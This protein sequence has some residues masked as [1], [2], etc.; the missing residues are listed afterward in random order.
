MGVV[1]VQRD[2][3]LIFESGYGYAN[4]ASRVPLGPDT[5]FPIASLSKQFTA[6]A[7]L[8]LQEH[9]KLKTSDSIRLYYPNAPTQW[10]K[11]MLRN[12][13]TQTSGIPDFDFARISRDSPHRPEEL[14]KEAVSKPLKFDPG[15][16]NEYTN[17]NYILLGKVVERAS[18]QSFCHFMRDHIFR[19]LQ[20]H[21]TG[22]NWKTH[23]ANTAHGYR[24][25]AQGPVEYEDKDL[26]SLAGAGSLY[27]SARDMIR[28]TEALQD[29]TFLSKASLAEMTTP[30]LDG[31]AYGL[32]VDGEGAEL[33]ISHDGTVEGF[34]S[35][36][37]YIPATRTTVVVLS[38]LNAE[39]NLSSPGTAALDTEV[40][41]LAID[42]NAVLPSAGA[43]AKVPEDTLHRYAGRYRSNDALHPVNIT[44]TFRDNRLFI[45]NDT[46]DAAPLFAES[47]TRFY[48]KNQETE[49][50]FD[51]HVAGRFYF[52]NYA[53]IGGAEFD[54]I[55][56]TGSGDLPPK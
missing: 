28:W 13:L 38:N 27:S 14:L 7:I 2:H 50:I 56:E 23:L 24:P 29:G 39:G 12:L 54:R 21:Q 48:L 1:A 15:T 17:I 25:S 32:K 40:V 4:V 35:F 19:P 49:I 37:D 47:A 44:L 31:Y 20:L 53:P 8:L 55:P 18:G 26:N 3:H 45:Q 9:G 10:S 5:R 43:E 16:K 36:L 6:A 52:L 46:S 51:D 30:F 42:E 34:F 22:C 11:I 33:D 41:R